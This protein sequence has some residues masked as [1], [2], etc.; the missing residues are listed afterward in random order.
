M[1]GYSVEQVRTLE[2]RA[3]SALPDGVLMQRAAAGL[4]AILAA[5]LVRRRGGV[6]GARVL[7]MV[8]PGNNGGDALYAGARLARRGAS[9]TA[10]R[11]VGTPH[12]A[13]LA[14]LQAAGG[15]VTELADPGRPASTSWTVDLAV[16]GIFGIGGRPGLPDPVAELAVSLQASGVP[17]VAVDLP[18]GVECDTGAVP[19]ASFHAVRTVTFGAMKIC[20]LVEPARS[21]CGELDLVDIGLDLSGGQPTLTAAEESMLASSWPFPDERSNK[22]TRGVVGIDTGS[23]A[24]PG[25][26]ILSTHGAVYAGAGMVRFL[27]PA[28][29][30]QVIRAELPNVVFA[31][32]RVQ[33]RLFG[34]GWG[35]R[36]DGARVIAEALE[37]ELPSVVDADGLRYLPPRLPPSWLLTPHAGEL[38]R[39]LDGDRA[40]VEADPIGAVRAGADLTGATVLL[41]GATQLVARPGTSEVQ[42]AIP[43]PAWTGQAGSGD[44]LAGV[45]ATLLAAGKRADAAAV[46]GAS[47]QAVTAAS[48]PGPLPPH[49]LA[50]HFARV[51][52]ALESRA[53]DRCGRKDLWTH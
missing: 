45:C 11:C 21:R 15:V 22:Y 19:A 28:A 29:A 18:S 17:V 35:E 3:M 30:A 49:E 6:Y 12:A 48:V 46:L 5:E 9:V 32:G 36:P 34:S 31:P 33:A 10:L 53:P 50:R 39:L 13:G 44:V 52:G 1:N 23:D 4:T 41:K 16:D 7:I 42:V 20:H 38:A 8:G 24:Y 27:G 37:S 2:Q 47:L 25:A 26:G 40:E 51:L 43:G 14:A